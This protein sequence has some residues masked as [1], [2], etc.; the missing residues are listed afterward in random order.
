MTFDPSFDPFKMR[1]EKKEKYFLLLL[2]L[3]DFDNFE[4]LTPVGHHTLT[5]WNLHFPNIFWQNKHVAL[6]LMDSSWELYNL[7]M[8]FIS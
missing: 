6:K 1:N 7:E 5:P 4:I 8:T 2:F 3:D